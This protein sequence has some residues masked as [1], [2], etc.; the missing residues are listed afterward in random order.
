[1]RVPPHH[2]ACQRC[3]A[4]TECGGVFEQNDD[5]WPEV[6]CREF[7]LPGGDLNPEFVCETCFTAIEA[8]LRYFLN[9]TS[10]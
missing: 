5:G 9:E 4:K 2:H 7:H 6:T 10:K 3:G 8:E 1:M